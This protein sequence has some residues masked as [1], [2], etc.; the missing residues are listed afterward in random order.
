MKSV[1]GK[2]RA[3]IL[4]GNHWLDP[5]EITK[6][7][8]A[9]SDVQCIENDRMRLSRCQNTNIPSPSFC[10]L[11]NFLFMKLPDTKFQLFMD[12]FNHMLSCNFQ[13][14][15]DSSLIFPKNF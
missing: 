12:P 11:S 5:A 7:R 4:E 8:I 6:N 3:S 14:N 10:S 13:R 1:I 15:Y 2:E 9:K